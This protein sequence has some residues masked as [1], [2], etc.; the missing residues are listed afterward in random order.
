MFIGFKY[1]LNSLL[2]FKK[3]NVLFSVKYQYFISCV[4][5]ISDCS[6]LRSR[7]NILKVIY[8]VFTSYK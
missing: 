5:N 4:E 2:S 1:A 6:E 3:E 7:V 8:M